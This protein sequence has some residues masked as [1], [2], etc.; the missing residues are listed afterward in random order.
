ME[1][2]RLCDVFRSFL[3]VKLATF[4][5]STLFAGCL[6]A[7]VVDIRLATIRANRALGRV[8]GMCIVVTALLKLPQWVEKSA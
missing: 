4:R 6:A 3:R 7:V 8:F 2:T 1:E 5:S